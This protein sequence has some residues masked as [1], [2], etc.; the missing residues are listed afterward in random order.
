MSDTFAEYEKQTQA[1]RNKNGYWINS[2]VFR[3]E[4]LH[5]I[6]YG[7][8]C[9]DPWG[10]PSWKTY[11]ETQLDRCINGYSVGDAYITGH[12]Y[13]YLN[14]SQ[15][16]LE[17]NKKKI[18]SFPDFWDGDYN[19][20]WAVD[21]ARNG[22]SEEFLQNLQLDI[23]I[24][25]EY[26]NGGRHLMVGKARRKGYSFKNGAICANT[27]NTVKNSLTLIT[28][29][30]NK[31]AFDTMK[32][33]KDFIN[34]LD[35]NT[36]WRK[37][38]LIDK[39]SHVKSG[40]IEYTEGV[41]VIKG[42]QSEIEALTF[43]DNPDAARGKD[44]H[45]IL[46]E[47][48]GTFAN[49]IDSYWATDPSTKA[50]D[51]RT[52]QIIMFGTG[53]DMDRGTI[54]FNEM[55]Y[56]PTNYNILPVVNI[57]DESAEDSDC[58]FFHPAYWNKEGYY[59]L[60]GNSHIDRAKE[61]EEKNR[62]DKTTSYALRKY[63]TE[64]PFT[65]AEA[66]QSSTTNIFPT[67]ELQEQKTKVEVNKLHLKYGQP[68]NLV[69]DEG[70]V[71]AKPI[72]KT[73]E[74]TPIYYKKPKSDDLR[75][76][77]VIYEYPMPNAP[78]G[79]YKMGYDPY[80]QD[81]SDGTSLGCVYVYKSFM[82]GAYTKNKIVAMYIGR[83]DSAETVNRISLLFAELYNTE[84]MHEN[85]FIHVKNYFIKQKALGRLARQPDK[86]ISK[87]IKKS[88][89]TRV[90]GCHMTDEL[91]DAG[92]NYIKDWLL[93]VQDYDEEGNPVL[94]LEQIYDIGLLEEL[95]KYNRK[96]NFDRVMAFMMIMFQ[97]QEDVLDHKT[98]E[99]KS[100]DEKYA[101][102]RKLD[103]FYQKKKVYL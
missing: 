28:G 82:R 91:K 100:D 94:A 57:W 90:W 80:A 69:R 47:E 54:D 85:M 103:S 92:E 76:C 84:V 29:F 41:K 1:V 42:Y 102:K 97:I 55:F 17:K 51:I 95:I 48:M 2:Q 50:G 44:A 101:F 15:I 45:L 56:D 6:K 32:K 72:L 12:H 16:K 7:Y 78:K 11:W 70:K 39:I 71:K 98:Y 68:I 46:M 18:I 87:N 64:Y 75:G 88:G 21:I 81:Q 37:N 23:R 83:P 79:V 38:K 49:A 99:Q 10:S 62:E 9:P 24:R 66:F 40:Y 25:P 14:F 20:F 96:G 93:S 30:D 43:Q 73:N 74:V 4:A 31:Y 59:D 33:T 58:A 67:K 89:V 22:C 52:G 63:T 13:F 53:G 77:P 60:Q 26:L 34:F 36:G 19:Y 86:V 3:E 65:P 61:S 8:Y 35:D 27:Y 5:F